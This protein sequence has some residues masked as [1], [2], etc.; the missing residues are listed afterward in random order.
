M[1]KENNFSIKT[2]NLDSVLELNEKLQLYSGLG[3][4]YKEMYQEAIKLA[5]RLDG[6]LELMKNKI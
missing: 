1:I 6:L 3:N 5:I 2:E 4:P